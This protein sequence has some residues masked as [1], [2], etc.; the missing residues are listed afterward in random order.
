MTIEIIQ[1]AG[2]DVTN[3]QEDDDIRPMAIHVKGASCMRDVIIGI[4]E[5]AG[6]QADTADDD[7]R[8]MAVRAAT[9]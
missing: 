1:S 9:R 5:S 7:M 8:P 2:F 6:F 4:L 3:F